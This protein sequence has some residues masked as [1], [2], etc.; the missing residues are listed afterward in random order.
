MASTLPPEEPTAS[1]PPE[2]EPIEMEPDRFH[3]LKMV[4][5][6]VLIPAALLLG[7]YS[8]LEYQAFHQATAHLE[9]AVA[10]GDTNRR[11]E[12]LNELEQCLAAYPE[13]YDAYNYMA[14]L[15]YQNQDLDG[16]AKAYRRGLAALPDHGLMNLNMA[17]VL[18]AQQD[19]AA[20]LPYAQKAKNLLPGDSRPDMLIK[21]CNDLMSQGARQ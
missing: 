4:A 14:T 7:Y 12:A 6:A 11:Q 9:Q 13:Y 3:R 5:L 10:L 21:R 15:H 2:E 18:V 20:A 16:A 1:E 17:E 8:Y 19:Y